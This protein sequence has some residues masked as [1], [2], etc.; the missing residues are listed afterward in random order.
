MKCKNS[1]LRVSDTELLRC[2]HRMCHSCL[3]GTFE[4]SLEDPL[5]TPPKCC[6]I[7]PIP[8]NLVA[9]LFENEEFFNKWKKKFNP[10]RWL[11]D[12]GD[13]DS[14]DEGRN[15]IQMQFRKVAREL[16]PKKRKNIEKS[17]EPRD[18]KERVTREK[19]ANIT[20]RE[21]R[22]Q[23]KRQ[24]EKKRE[25]RDPEENLRNQ[26]KESRRNVRKP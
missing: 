25:K 7:N 6:T 3:K 2:G 23:Y 26:E 11:G 19:G 9:G 5:G 21:H 15:P 8:L 10:R 16:W 17:P 12:G 14:E 1:N 4:L 20:E 24:Q 18:M 13:T 22:Y